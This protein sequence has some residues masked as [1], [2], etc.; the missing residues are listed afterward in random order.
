M[1]KFLGTLIIQNIILLYL[2]AFIP[3]YLALK[4]Y[5]AISQ[6]DLIFL[7]TYL[8][9]VIIISYLNS[10]LL[11]DKSLSFGFIRFFPFLIL[12]R[13]FN[14]V[15]KEKFPSVSLSNYQKYIIVIHLM[16]GHAILTEEE[17]TYFSRLIK[18]ATDDVEYEF[19]IFIETPFWG[20]LH[21]GTDQYGLRRELFSELGLR[22]SDK[23]LAIRVL[24]LV[25]I[26]LLII[27]FISLQIRLF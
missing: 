7:S 26:Y 23:S 11:M 22:Y 5:I 27:A 18:P 20:E 10:F 17:Y 25:I 2:F 14:K 12:L 13:R 19:S 3:I 24:I 4:P 16:N 1:N 15:L 21:E 9:L 6:Y 8:V